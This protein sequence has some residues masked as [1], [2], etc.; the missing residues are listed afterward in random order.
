MTEYNYDRDDIY[1]PDFRDEY[2]HRHYDQSYYETQYYE[3]YQEQAARQ[4]NSEHMDYRQMYES[5]MRNLQLRQTY[6]DGFARAR[7]NLRALP[8][9]S[10]SIEDYFN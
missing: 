1:R 6:L 5:R 10:F 8:I 7:V 3:Y 9:E 2:R 4:R